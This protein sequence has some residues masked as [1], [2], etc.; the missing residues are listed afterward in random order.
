M[1]LAEKNIRLKLL[2]SCNIPREPGSGLIGETLVSTQ[3]QDTPQ[4]GPNSEMAPRPKPSLIKRLIPWLI[5]LACFAFLY[6]RI[7]GPA[8]AQG[9]SVV[10]YLTTVFAS[11][12]WLAWLALMIPYSL[13]FFAIDS[14]IVWRVINWFDAK[15]AYSDILQFEQVPTFC[16]SSTNRL[17]KGQW[18]CT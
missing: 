6:T 1:G 9:M 7:A 3:E 8:A 5:T 11:V 4:T 15:V 10:A 14:L 12:N 18:P 16:R 2:K 13:F 17:A